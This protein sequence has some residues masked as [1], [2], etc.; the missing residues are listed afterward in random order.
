MNWFL[1]LKVRNKILLCVVMQ[2]LL[3]S[4]VSLSQFVSQARRTAKQER[5]DSARNLVTM[6]ESVR[7][8][9]AK[10]WEVGLFEQKQLV[11]WAEAGEHERIFATVPIVSA[12]EAVAQRADMNGYT[13]KTPR[14][15]A[16]NSNNEPD[17]VESRALSAFA[18]DSQLEEFSEIDTETNSLRYFRPI[19]LTKDCMICHGDPSTS[20]ALWNNDQGCDITGYK[21]E[22]A[23]V[24]DLH[25]AFEII[26]SLD[27]SEKEILASIKNSLITLGLVLIPSLGFLTWIV[28]R[29]IMRPIH[30]TIATLKDIAEGEGDLTRRLNAKNTDELGELAR[31]FNLFVEKI[32]EIVSEIARD[33]SSLTTSSS[34]LSATAGQLSEG[35]V[36]SKL[37][38]ATVSSAA[39]ELSI[40]MQNVSGNA[41]E[42]TSNIR[43][44]SQSVENVKNTIGSISHSAEESASVANQAAQLAEQS[45]AR[46]ATLGQ[47][48]QEIGKVIEVIED[49]AEQT[50]LLAL[51]ATIEAARAGEAGKGFAVVATEVK[52]LAKQTA[53]AIDDIRTRIQ[54]IQT[55]TGAA[56]E[57]I[58]AIDKVISQVNALNRAIA[59]SVEEQSQTTSDIVD[60]ITGTAG[61]A[62]VISRNISESAFASREITE[63]IARVDETLGETAEGAELS[64][65]AGVQLSELANKMQTLVG[66]FRLRPTEHTAV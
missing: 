25:G 5:I 51:N 38:S 29:Y 65:T 4:G 62:E 24:G 39:E 7:D 18:E 21:M 15:G 57:S 66:Q 61:L 26:E 16:R 10:K 19:R 44:V 20:L 43:N 42:M 59:C 2:T 1:G 58:R 47:S 11:E 8:G 28:S 12:W 27:G 6:A 46:I 30:G 37:Q 48:A 53:A 60:S 14:H 50:N 23:K 9:M 54:A 3:L 40:G 55:S 35:T 13:I 17:L 45:N 34:K 32:H 63:N 49:I 22:G 33:A 31:W 41:E 52:Q 56:V 36:R 64:K